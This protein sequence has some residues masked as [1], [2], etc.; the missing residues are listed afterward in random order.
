MAGSQEALAVVVVVA[1]LECCAGARAGGVCHVESGVVA[2]ADPVAG[3]CLWGRIVWASCFHAGER[4]TALLEREAA[5]VGAYRVAQR[6][7]AL[8]GVRV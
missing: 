5:G 7:Q 4:S 8:W 1:V 2:T 3:G 6:V